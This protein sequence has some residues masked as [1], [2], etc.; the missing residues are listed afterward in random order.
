MKNTTLKILVV[1]LAAAMTS[2]V[3]FSQIVG[4]RQADGSVINYMDI[5]KKKQGKW[6]KKYDN[7]QVRYEGYFTNDLPSGTFNYY[8]ENGKQKSILVYAEDHSATVKMFWENGGRAA[9]GGYDSERLRHGDWLMY[10][11]AGKLIETIHYV[12]GKADGV[13]KVYYPNTDRL[14]LDCVYADGKRNGYYK[15]YFDNGNIHEDGFYKDN[16]KHGHW[17]IYTPDGN[18]EEE[19]DYVNGY[20]EGEWMD[21][22][23]DKAGEL[24]NYTRGHSDK[25]E[26]EM[27]EWQ[28]KAEWAKEHQ[29]QFMRPEDYLDDPI[30]FF[31][32]NS[33]VDY[34]LPANNNTRESGSSST[35]KNKK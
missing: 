33:N 11:E 10:T 23:K 19:G 18:L 29:D 28:R 20:R 21:Y 24:V 31:Q 26:E 32:H 2:T 25:E 4:Q 34:G 13:V 5:N 1:A 7:G 3:A 8:Y 6:V 15:Y 14:A 16:T 35:K 30:Q 27:K 9:E 22:R 17:K 12:H